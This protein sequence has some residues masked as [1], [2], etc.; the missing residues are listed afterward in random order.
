MHSTA[1]IFFTSL[2]DNLIRENILKDIE[3]FVTL[4]VQVEQ[5]FLCSFSIRK[6]IMQRTAIQREKVKE[7]TFNRW[8]T[9]FRTQFLRGAEVFS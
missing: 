7:A 2:L 8:L 1:L 9:I 3:K 5:F 6:T 4:V